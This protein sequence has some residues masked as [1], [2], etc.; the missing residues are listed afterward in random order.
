LWT[1]FSE[2]GLATS[3]DAQNR[4]AIAGF[5][6]SVWMRLSAAAV[7]T[8]KLALDAI[9]SAGCGTGVGR[10][11]RLKRQPIIVLGWRLFI[12]AYRQNL[13][14]LSAGAGSYPWRLRILDVSRACW[15]AKGGL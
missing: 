10:V 12:F 1:Y 14:R 6:C 15:P 5:L 7:R 4:G 9:D 11:L 2:A 8:L 13:W 3:D